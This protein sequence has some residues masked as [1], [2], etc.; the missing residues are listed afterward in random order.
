MLEQINL[1]GVLQRVEAFAKTGVCVIQQEGQWVELYFEEGRLMCI[2]P[3][4]ASTTLGDRLVEAGVISPQA[5]QETLLC[6][7]AA[8]L[9]EM[10]MALT[11]MDLG[12]VDREALRTW[13]EQEAVEV[14]RWLLT[15]STGSIYFE[16]DGAPPSD[17]LLV[18]L[19]ITSL[20]SL[21]E[22]ASIF[23]ANKRV[24]HLVYAFPTIGR[25]QQEGVIFPGHIANAPTLLDPSQFL[26]EAASVTVSPF[27]EESF[28]SQI[29]PTHTANS[30]VAVPF[31]Q[32]VPAVPLVQTMMPRGIGT[33]FMG[34]DMVLVPA[35]L[36]PVR[37]QNPQIALTPDQWRL[38]TQADGR[39][40]LQMACQVLGWQPEMI[41]QV[42]N[43]LIAK[44]L[45]H[46]VPP[47]SEYLQELS[48]ASPVVITSSQ[49][50][51]SPA[52]GF[53]TQNVPLQKTAL[54][55]PNPEVLP[56]YSPTV[57][58][59]TQSQWGNG[60]KGTVFVPGRGWVRSNNM[61]PMSGNEYAYASV[62][63]GG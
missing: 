59:E 61:M 53:G 19:S 13:A 29:G 50:A 62:G 9:S 12:Y 37:E 60:E 49:R 45:L 16:E 7:G 2:G 28:V 34:P 20:L 17:R 32:E 6:T 24:N 18:A 58:F 47:T 39:T 4:G 44:G 43:E 23:D 36:S 11:L 30:A 55:A 38:L 10:R 41:R 22:D 63:G 57:S 21:F 46:V 3:L 48:P 5:L 1:V 35:D 8:E 14:L 33:T 26:N 27:L 31:Q 56:Q 54:G 51:I 25:E 15:W 52:P 40:S 42:A